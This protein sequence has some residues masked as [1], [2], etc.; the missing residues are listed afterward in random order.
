M[1][2]LSSGL[3]FVWLGAVNEGSVL[4][5]T[6]HPK[7]AVSEDQNY[8]ETQPEIEETQSDFQ[9]Q[10]YDMELTFGHEL[11]AKVTASIM[12]GN[13]PKQC[14]FTLYH[15][16]KISKI[17]SNEGETLSFTPGGRRG[18]GRDTA[19]NFATHILL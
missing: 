5:L 18:G 12:S 7:S 11:S 10:A 13:T 4:R 3:P 17:E 15:G 2:Y 19:A 8:Y 14:Y 6:D 1:V 9:V 16:Y